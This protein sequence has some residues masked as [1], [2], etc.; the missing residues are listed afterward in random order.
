MYIYVYMYVYIYIYIYMYI[1]I[2][3]CICIYVYVYI[4]NMYVD[5]GFLPATFN[6]PRANML[7]LIKTRV[8][9]DSTRSELGSNDEHPLE[10]G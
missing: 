10:L 1:C 5:G 4:Y 9:S 7:D 8:L 3:V 2:Y 6:Y